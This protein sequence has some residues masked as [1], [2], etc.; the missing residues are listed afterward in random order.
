MLEPPHG[1]IDVLLKGGG[2]V[3]FEFQPYSPFL[4]KNRFS[5]KQ[6]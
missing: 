5:I 3:N 4:D 1:E 6:A 2:I